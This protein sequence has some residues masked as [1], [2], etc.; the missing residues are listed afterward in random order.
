[1]ISTQLTVYTIEAAPLNNMY[2]YYSHTFKSILVYFLRK[3]SNIQQE[4]QKTT[5]W[6]E[7][8]MMLGAKVNLLLLL[9]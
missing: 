6:T 8:E 7:G 5:E 1:M 2:V 3:A 4:R 9:Y